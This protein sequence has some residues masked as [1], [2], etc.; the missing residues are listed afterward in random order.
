MDTETG[1]AVAELFRVAEFPES[2]LGAGSDTGE[3]RIPIRLGN[4]RPGEFFGFLGF[5]IQ[6]LGAPLI[7]VLLLLPLLGFPQTLLS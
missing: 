7:L 4:G 1:G 2:G 3:V 5:A 6:K